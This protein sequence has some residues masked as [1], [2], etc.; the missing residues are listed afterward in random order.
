MAIGDRA[1]SSAPDRPRRAVLTVDLG[2]TLR[3]AVAERATAEGLRVSD[4]VRQ[5]VQEHIASGRELRADQRGDVEPTEGVGRYQPHLDAK[6]AAKLDELKLRTGRRTRHGVLRALIDGINLAPAGGSQ[7]LGAA[8]QQ[9]IRSNAE[10]VAI[11]RNLNQVAHSL[12]LYPGKTTAADRQ[13]IERTVGAV[14]DHLEA[15]A[16]LAAE[17]RP[18]VRL[19]DEPPPAAPRRAR[20][21]RKAVRKAAG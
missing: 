8:V 7:N 16:R 21:P 19:P 13:A 6:Y 3:A 20:G 9:L 15:A 11:G 5:A 2:S 12:N 18:L 17:I 10:L 14:Y 4:V 1:A